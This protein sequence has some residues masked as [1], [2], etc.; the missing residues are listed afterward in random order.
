VSAD[1]D[2]TGVSE[3]ARPEDAEPEVTTDAVVEAGRNRPPDLVGTRPEWDPKRLVPSETPRAAAGRL[4]APAGGEDT[5]ALP[6]AA[7]A[8]PDAQDGAGA[9]AAPAF[10][11]LRYSRYS[12]R[13][14][15]LLGALVAVGAAAIVLL[16]AVIAGGGKSDSTTI[17]LRSG[18]AWSDWH[19]TAVGLE[20]ARQIAEH[21]SHE[22][23]Q[24]DRRQLVIVTGGP[25]ALGALPA[26]IAIQRPADQGGDIDLLDG[27]A[28]LYR[29]SGTHDRKGHVAGKPSP[30]L[31]LLLRREALE[32][33]LYSFR[34][35]GV[36]DAVVLLPPGVLAPDTPVTK[37]AGAQTQ[38]LL[39]RHSE[40]ALQTAIVRPLKE[41]LAHETPSI[42]GVNSSSDATRVTKLTNSN[43][44]DSRFQVDTQDLS[45]FL[46]LDP[47]PLR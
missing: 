42:A 36:S 2:T 41:T 3:D 20:A 29:M 19:P 8:S 33:A 11:A 15:F 13:F 46:L 22:Y 32:L 5:E 23:H 28:V 14:Q 45:A 47:H 17:A 9:Q 43:L 38:A 18:P 12:A 24:P 1:D 27:S 7:D 31:H 44:F 39:F 21:V 35:L 25:L 30:D 26:T 40:A 4:W 6:A 34:Y 10:E 16:V 37:A